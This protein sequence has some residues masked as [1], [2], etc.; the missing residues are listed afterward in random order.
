MSVV[1][2]LKNKFSKIRKRFDVQRNPQMKQKDQEVV[3]YLKKI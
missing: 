2:F 1:T 3:S